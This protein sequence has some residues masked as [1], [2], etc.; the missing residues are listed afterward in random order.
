MAV[1][2]LTLATRQGAA[3]FPDIRL[4]PLGQALD[5]FLALGGSGRSHHFLIGGVAP[6]QPDI[7]HDRLIKEHDILEHNGIVL[8]QRF[9]L[10]SPG[11]IG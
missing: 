5:K 7:L 10:P 11:R 1:N 8:E 3:I 6:A 2:A 9:R 4:I